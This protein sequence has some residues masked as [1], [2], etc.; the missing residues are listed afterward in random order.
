M[1]ELDAI[2][3]RYQ[4]DPIFHNMTNS[5]AQLMR[6]GAIHRSDIFDMLRMADHICYVEEMRAYEETL[7]RTA[8]RASGAQQKGEE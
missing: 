3:K 5:M 8:P 6:S 7:R 4:N 1:S 2:I